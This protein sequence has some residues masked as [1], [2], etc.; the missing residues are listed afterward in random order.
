M[1]GQV[2]LPRASEVMSHLSCLSPGLLYPSS[3]GSR[4]STENGGG[5]MVSPDTCSFHGAAQL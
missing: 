3:D 4:T 5:P 1:R 2:N